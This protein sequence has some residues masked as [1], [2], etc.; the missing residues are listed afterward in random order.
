MGNAKPGHAAHKLPDGTQMQLYI[1]G[2]MRR[3]NLLFAVNAG[4]I[5]VGT[6][7]R[8]GAAAVPAEFWILSCLAIFLT[9]LFVADIWVFGML[10]NRA[11]DRFFGPV[12]KLVLLLIGASLI[13]AWFVAS[14]HLAKEHRLVVGFSIVLAVGAFL[15]AARYEVVKSRET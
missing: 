4:L 9:G 13:S 2:K 1:D 12:G 10:F 6:F 8:G 3:Y 7:A 15:A 11:D 14:L 5:A